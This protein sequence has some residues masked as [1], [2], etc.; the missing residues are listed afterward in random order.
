[1]T[2]IWET[3]L[4]RNQIGI[5]DNFFDLG[6]H[7]LLAT[8]VMARVRSVFH[9][10]LPLRTLFEAPTVEQLAVFIENGGRE[11]ES[12]MVCLHSGES[13]APLYCFDPSGMH[14]QVY[15]P[16]AVSLKNDRP[17]LG[18]SLS[19]IF[20]DTWQN[21]SIEAIAERQVRLI[22][23][24]QPKGPYYLVG[25]SNGGVL[26]FAAA[27]Q[28]EQ[29]GQQVAFIGVLDTQPDMA[30]YE[31]K[32]PTPV[33]EVL[34]YIR[35]ECQETF[36]AIPEKAR[37]EFRK[38][39]EELPED[40]MLEYAVRWAQE[41]DFLSIE[42]AT[43]SIGT[44]K[45]KYAL[46][47]AMAFFMKSV[48]SCPIHSPVH[49]WWATNTL[50]R[51]GSAPMDWNQYT[52]GIVSVEIVVGDHMD[53]VQSIHVHQQIDKVLSRSEGVAPSR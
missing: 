45:L 20:S 18:L 52:T 39:L 6:G 50:A 31:S 51:H 12:G 9:V 38:R 15:R 1:M 34:A 5:H 48:Q 2:G 33:D 19:H 26:A 42:E 44:L 22:R 17:V 30:I 11:N 7:S 10:E 46:N 3:I 25:W 29:W 43:E 4:K 21:L 36:N 49:A 53:A 35:R 27:R 8:Q 28:L 13:L 37:N 16:L 40:K 24:R 14:V 32:D 47:R 23:E 41:R